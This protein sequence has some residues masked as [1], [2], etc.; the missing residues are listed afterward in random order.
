LEDLKISRDII[1]NRTNAY[2]LFLWQEIED[3]FEFYNK[4]DLIVGMRLHSIILACLFGKPFVVISLPK[5]HPLYDPK[6][7]GFLELLGYE[8]MD[9]A[10]PAAEIAGKVHEI[11]TNRQ[12]FLE[13]LTPRVAKLR[14]SSRKN[15]EMVQSLLENVS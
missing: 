9:M 2:K 1:A 13:K 6:V 8:A 12:K 3:L 10:V 15:I 11:W 14:E 5:T 7:E 4:I